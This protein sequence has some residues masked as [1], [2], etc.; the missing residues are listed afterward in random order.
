[1]SNRILL[2]QPPIRDFYFTRKRSI[3]YGLIS[4]AAALEKDGFPVLLVDGLATSKSKVIQTPSDMAY[5]EPFYGKEDLSPFSLFHT[6]R[7]FG[8]SVEHIGRMAR[9]SGA[10]LVGISSLFTAYA[11]EALEVAMEVRKQLPLSRIVLG[12]H[13]PTQLPEAVLSHPCVDFVVR[14]EGEAVMPHLARALVTGSPLDRI[15][16]LVFRK[17]SGALHMS[18]PSFMDRPDE[19]PLPRMDL[20]NHGFYGRKEGGSAVITASRGCPMKCTYCC[21]A[22]PASPYRKRSV[23][24]VF[25]EITQAVTEYGVRFI[26]FEDENLTLDKAWCLDLMTRITDHFGHLGL[27][28]RAM[29]GLFPPSL[30]DDLVAALKQAG[31]TALNLSVCT[32]SQRQL[33]RFR[34]VDV[35]EALERVLLSAK[36]HGMTSVCYILVGAPGQTAMESVDDLIYLGTKDTLAGVS[37]YYPAPGSFDYDQLAKTQG[38]PET[39][40]LMRSTAIPV[41]DSTTRLES[42]TLL[43]LG[44]ILN[45]SKELKKRNVSIHPLKLSSSEI[46]DPKDRFQVGITLINAFMEDGLIRGIDARGQVYVHTVDSNVC[47]AFRAKFKTA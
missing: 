44:R 14:G 4:I 32:L 29:N 41:S 6:F 13:H 12:G 10:F 19:F 38:L 28:L 33:K 9:E 43:R 26:D 11:D 30:D 42:V 27:E 1:M 35:R 5:L 46:L 17:D 20:V 8:Y 23:D 7:H 2:I 31:F 34:R 15:N 21:V 22:S 16:G 37:V 39:F 45:F 18:P 47:H 25:E 24:S 36:H 40:S 3:P